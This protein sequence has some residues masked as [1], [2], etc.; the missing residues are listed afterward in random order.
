M[1][2]DIMTTIAIGRFNSAMVLYGDY[3]TPVSKKKKPKTKKLSSLTEAEL[4]ILITL[5]NGT[6]H[7]QL[8]P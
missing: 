2:H 4:K 7:S 5:A 3:E 8:R 6:L 1:K